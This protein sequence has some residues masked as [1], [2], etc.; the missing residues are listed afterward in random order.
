M[1]QDRNHESQPSVAKA[2]RPWVI[3]LIVVAVLFLCCSAVLVAG[4][5]L[6]DPILEF[7]RDAGFELSL[8]R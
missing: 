2:R 5:F 7:L 8:I 3:V 6:G 4:W 1:T